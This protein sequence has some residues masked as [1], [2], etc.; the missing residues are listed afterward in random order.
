MIRQAHRPWCKDCKVSFDAD[1]LDIDSRCERCA[2][3][4]IV[5]AKY[6][7]QRAAREA[8]GAPGHTPPPKPKVRKPKPKPAGPSGRRLNRER[9]VEMYDEGKGLSSGQIADELHTTRKS[10]VNHLT[11]AGVWDPARE[12][13]GGRP[14]SDFCAE[15]HDQRK[16]RAESSPGKGDW[17]CGPCKLK[18]NAEYKKAQAV[19]KRDNRVQTQPGGLHMLILGGEE[20]GLFHAEWDIA[21]ALHE[22][23]QWLSEPARA[24]SLRGGR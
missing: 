22:R 14:K 20:V 11:L 2:G 23:L 1:Q 24:R 21:Q 8:A 5:K 19:K 12:G 3:L 15:G 6:A 4:A 17:H 7:D 9:I 13:K 18:R 10:V 16:H